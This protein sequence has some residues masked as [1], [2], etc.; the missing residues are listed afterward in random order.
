MQLRDI[1]KLVDELNTTLAPTVQIVRTSQHQVDDS[2]DTID[3]YNLDIYIT[4]VNSAQSQLAA[5]LA[6]LGLAS[7]QASLQTFN[8]SLNFD[9]SEM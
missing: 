9:F 6:S 5:A 2:K 8:T 7:I 1:T 4:Q 3:S